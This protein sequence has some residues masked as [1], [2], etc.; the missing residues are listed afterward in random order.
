MQCFVGNAVSAFRHLRAAKYYFDI[1]KSG[2]IE[3]NSTAVEPLGS[4]IV[5]LELVAQ[6]FLPIPGISFLG[7]TIGNTFN[8]IKLDGNDEMVQ[9]LD[10]HRIIAHYQDV[11][12]SI[13]TPL[14]GNITRL[15]SVQVNEFQ[16]ELRQWRNVSSDL[17]EDCDEEPIMPSL[18][19]SSW[20][21]LDELPIPPRP[22]YFSS[23]ETAITVAL[24][25]CFMAHTMWL[26]S[27]TTNTSH[28]CETLAYLYV[29]QI[30]RIAEGLLYSNPDRK[31]DGE[32]YFS[33]EALNIGL[34]PILYLSAQCCYSPAWQQWIVDK[35]RH[36]G[37]EGMFNSEAF[38]TCLSMLKSFQDT[39]KTNVL[40]EN[41]DV[42]QSRSPLGPPACRVIPT[43]LPD[44]DGSQF[45]GYYMR[46]PTGCHNPSTFPKPSLEVVG[47]AQW[48]VDG[49]D[50]TEQ[51][52]SA[53][54]HT[55]HLAVKDLSD[56]RTEIEVQ[57]KRWEMLFRNTPCQMSRSIDD[58][59]NECDFPELP[60]TSTH[61]HA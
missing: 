58:Y 60:K 40:S 57:S 44:P 5:R 29:Y 50:S 26:L 55:D 45:T 24:Y 61:T 46:L 22:Q 4:C 35:L 36:I 9:I 49:S 52:W 32:R 59:I 48:R 28:P 39:E 14:S 54:I 10:L 3:Q 11:T 38:A 43:L 47:R 13:L 18:P 31:R 27:I 33:S 34:A 2:L 56:M 1:A 51:K 8:D 17:F 20:A 7:E 30:I 6:L 12:R 19:S 42:W 16:T 41:D 53:D 25:N 37:R 21:S 23:V 15:D